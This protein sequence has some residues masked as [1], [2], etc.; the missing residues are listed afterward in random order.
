MKE[1]ENLLATKTCQISPLHS[2]TKINC[3]PFPPKHEK[4]APKKPS[5]TLVSCCFASA[6]DIVSGRRSEKRTQK[7]FVFS[8]PKKQQ[9]TRSVC[10]NVSFCPSFFSS[11][12]PL[13]EAF[14]QM[15]AHREERKEKRKSPAPLFPCGQKLVRRE[16]RRGSPS[17][18]AKQGH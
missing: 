12:P 17:K 5:S 7:K 13:S 6:A 18:Q 11:P 14:R 10:E 1:T 2:H 3:S 15:R 9:K 4:D 16:G 8:S